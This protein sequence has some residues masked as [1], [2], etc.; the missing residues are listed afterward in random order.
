MV[1]LVNLEKVAENVKTMWCTLNFRI[2]VL[3]IILY[4]VPMSVFAQTAAQS[5]FKKS[6]F[7]AHFD[8]GSI[9]ES[10]NENFSFHPTSL[11]KLLTI[12]V[13]FEALTQNEIS[14]STQYA[15]SENAWRTGGAPSQKLTMFAELGSIISV[16]NLLKGLIIQ[17]ANDA[18]I[19][20]AEGISGSEEKFVERMNSFATNLG[21]RGSE[22]TDATGLNLTS[23]KT[24]AYDMSL[25]VT[26]IF[27]NY[28][29]LNNY[30][31]EPS[32]EWNEILQRNKNFLF[33]SEYGVDLLMS[34]FGQQTGY[35]FAG[36]ANF[37]GKRIFIVITGLKEEN[38]VEIAEQILIDSFNKLVTVKLYEKTKTISYANVFGGEQNQVEM[39]A[40]DEISVSLLRTQAQDLSGKI[41]FS[42]P[43][44]AP[45]SRGD[46]IG[47]L[48]I[49]N[50]DIELRK[51]P[52]L[53]KTSVAKGSLLQRA[54]DGLEELLLGW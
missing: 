40:G 15:V 6:Q 7:I 34:G 50:G 14:L 13:V 35:S 24:T 26:H 36:T 45:I 49:W 8:T 53:A 33:E 29:E 5:Q 37:N 19:I 48:F 52:L 18:A 27:E 9:L 30:F 31:T 20:L 17:H 41:V 2:V 54:Q 16:E 28:P 44:I 43:L 32:F 38:R 39:V 10:E 22:F 12:A 42:E 4:F 46:L 3:T 23:G 11:T 47:H 51:I 25:L 1:H 21:M